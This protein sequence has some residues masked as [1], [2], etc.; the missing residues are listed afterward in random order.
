[1]LYILERHFIMDCYIY[2]FDKNTNFTSFAKISSR[3]FDDFN[4]LVLCHGYW[5]VIGSSQ[6][7]WQ[8]LLDLCDRKPKHYRK[9]HVNLPTYIN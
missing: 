1:M 3:I 4:K 2:K 8:D 9:I 6:E 7:Y 5:D